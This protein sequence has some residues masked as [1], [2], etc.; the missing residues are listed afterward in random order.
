MSVRPIAHQPPAG[1][2]VEDD[3]LILDTRN[4]NGSVPQY[5]QKV[6]GATLCDLDRLGCLACEHCPFGLHR[7]FLSLKVG[8]D[9]IQRRS[10]ASFNGSV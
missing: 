9:L 7:L 8:N 1:I 10:V 4:R 6:W 3:E 2:P 5:R